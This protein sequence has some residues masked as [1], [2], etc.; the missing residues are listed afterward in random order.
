MRFLSVERFAL[1]LNVLEVLPLG[2]EK[3]LIARP[4]LLSPANNG[5][6]DYRSIG[7][8]GRMP[9]QLSAPPRLFVP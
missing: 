8:P 9:P 6:K 4:S 1:P 2:M 3:K 7:S 5:R